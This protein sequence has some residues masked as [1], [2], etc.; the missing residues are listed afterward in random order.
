MYQMIKKLKSRFSEARPWEYATHAG[1]P[2]LMEVIL[3]GQNY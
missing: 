3:E 1:L 2:L